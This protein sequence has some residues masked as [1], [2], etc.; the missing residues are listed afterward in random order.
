[1]PHTRSLLRVANRLMSD[2]ASAEDLVQETM[3]S[4]WR[5]FHQFEDGTNARAWLFRI[6]MN[7]FYAQGRKNRLATVSLGNSD[8]PGRPNAHQ[9]AA[10]VTN[11]LEQ[12]PV[13]H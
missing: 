6:L 1:M 12:L 4:A 8:F 3:L 13:E 2:P 9:L 7:A 5:G 11:A 10:E